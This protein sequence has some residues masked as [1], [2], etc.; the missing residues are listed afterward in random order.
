MGTS[1]RRHHVSSSAVEL[2]QR[3]VQMRA[4]HPAQAQGA[5]LLERSLGV[6]MAPL[7]LPYDCTSG[8]VDTDLYVE[9]R[10]ELEDPLSARP[11]QA[12]VV[13]SQGAPSTAAMSSAPELSAGMEMSIQV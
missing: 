2:T 7:M 3:C 4:C 12:A 1:L 13:A 8:C 5:L 6:T 11:P 10:C 9:C